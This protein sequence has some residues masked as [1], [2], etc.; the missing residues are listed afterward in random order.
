MSMKIHANRYSTR[1][2]VKS[3]GRVNDF[4]ERV[5]YKRWENDLRNLE[6]IMLSLL[7]IVSVRDL[8]AYERK[9]NALK[10]I[11]F[12][13]FITLLVLKSSH[14]RMSA[15]YFFPFSDPDAQRIGL[16]LFTYIIVFFVVIFE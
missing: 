8:N 2:F 12:K 11:F 13:F 6:T 15:Q 1:M 10:K 3:D 5:V 16:N 9:K 7:C 4:P 14:E